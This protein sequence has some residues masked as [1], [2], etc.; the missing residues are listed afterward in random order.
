MLAG[1]LVLGQVVVNALQLVTFSHFRVGG[2]VYE[3]LKATTDSM[4]ELSAAIADVHRLEASL[5]SLGERPEPGEVGLLHAQ[6]TELGAGF[7][8]RFAR[9]RTLQAGAGGGD[10]VRDAAATWELV[11]APLLLR[12]S[13]GAAFDRRDFAAFLDG[14]HRQQR[15]RLAAE[16]Q[17]ALGALRQQVA[18]LE[19]QTEAEVQRRVVMRLAAGLTAAAILFMLFYL[20][21]RSILR[22]LTSLVR[23]AERVGQGDLSVELP[24][25]SGDEL[26][27]VAEGLGQMVRA[28]RSMVTVLAES[29]AQVGEAAA[30][31]IDVASEQVA[32]AQR[33]AS[34]VRQTRGIAEE[35]RQTSRVASERAEHLRR[36]AET[37]SGVG[38]AGAASLAASRGGIESI[39]SGIDE[40]GERIGS[41]GDRAR[42]LGRVA[43]T[44]KDITDQ[45]NMLALNAAMEAMRAGEH[46]KAFAVVAREMR[47]LTNR[48]AESAEQIARELTGTGEA[49]GLAVAATERGRA[50]MS[51]GL[52]EIEASA[53]TLQRLS[54][55]VNQSSSEVGEIAAAVGQQDAGIGQVF[56]ALTELTATLEQNE[57]NVARIRESIALLESAAARVRDAAG[58]FRV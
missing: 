19:Q 6:V 34:T 24:A 14:P 35:I 15:A 41:L 13:S 1:T 32:S 56:T 22:P 28:L 43:R 18:R 16:L 39:K 58:T 57:G 52:K 21:S 27:R 9:V 49:L 51:V 11:Q 7:A 26:G 33:Q 31:M 8:A 23:L 46:G 40:I 20:V 55:M 30:R 36:A 54:E 3:V 25:A 17:E 45:T 53:R 48:A 2:P 29:A 12:L 47:S 42:S 5:R 37:A 50:G 10:P 38:Q 44:I 4:N